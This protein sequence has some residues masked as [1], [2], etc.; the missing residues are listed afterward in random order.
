LVK[1][2]GLGL[3]ES[4][5]NE[6]KV[7]LEQGDDQVKKWGLGYERRIKIRGHWG[8]KIP[9]ALHFFILLTPASIPLQFSNSP[10]ITGLSHAYPL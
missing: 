1:N 5:G 3:G 2:R 6:N 9:H 4:L 7:V 8:V 10:T